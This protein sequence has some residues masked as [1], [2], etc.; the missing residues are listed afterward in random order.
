M[1][2]I[3]SLFLKYSSFLNNNFLIKEIIVNSIKDV[4]KIT[5]DKNKISINGNNIKLKLTAVEKSEIFISKIKIL[6]KINKNKNSIIFKDI[7]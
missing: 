1:D 3:S 2:K 7:K 5:I 6:E 4:T